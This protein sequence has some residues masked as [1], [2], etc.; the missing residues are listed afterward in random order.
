MSSDTWQKFLDGDKDAF[1]ELYSF[2]INDLFAYGLKIGFD[3]ETCKDAIQDVFFKLY[4]SKAQLLHV[5]NIEFYLLQSLKNRLFDIYNK[6]V[7]ISLIDPSEIIIEDN[8]NII[9]KLIH[10]EDLEYYREQLKQSLKKLK[11]KQQRIIHYHYQ[12]NLSHEEIALILDMTPEA[13]KK[14]I[15]RSVKKI[16]ETIAGSTMHF[17]S[18]LLTI[19]S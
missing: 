14:S 16:K 17:T 2:Y 4:T 7:K 6:E 18:I 8:G 1:S 19:F 15:Y 5:Q 3:E 9:E 11:P 10:D 12:L 13:V